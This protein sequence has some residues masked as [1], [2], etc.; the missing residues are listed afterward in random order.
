[1][2]GILFVDDEPG[3]LAGL[4]G[5]L[6]KQRNDW[7]MAFVPSGAEALRELATAPLRRDR[8]RHAHAPDGRGGAAAPGAE[9]VSARRPDRTVRADRRGGQPPAG[10]RRPSVHRQAVRGARAAPDHRAHLRSAAAAGSTGA[11]RGGGAA[12]PAAG[13]AQPVRPSGR[14]AVRAALVHDRRRGGDRAGRRRLGEDAAAGELGLLRVAPAGR[15][16]PHGGLVPGAG[17]GEDRGAVRGDA[18]RPDQL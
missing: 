12:G 2:K 14:G 6:R 7:H 18:R 13:E 11:A 3:V 10:P 16:H 1:M 9:A 5:L 8:L 17:A 15:R 4:S